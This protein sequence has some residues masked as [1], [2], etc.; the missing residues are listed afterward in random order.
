MKN[1][2][3]FTLI[4]LLV[5]V[6]IIG[7]LAVVAVPQYQIAVDKA[8]ATQI[9][10]IA[11]SIKDA[12]ERYY[13]ANGVYAADLEE[14]D[15]DVS[16][17]TQKGINV[18]YVACSPGNEAAGILLTGLG[19][20]YSKHF[21]QQCSNMSSYVGKHSCLASP[22]NTR[23]NLLCAALANQPPKAVS[24]CNDYCRYYF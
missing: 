11:K 4:E 8:K 10:T 1:K 9:V 15:I 22:S 13:L 17:L 23:G 20:R 19:V 18:F 5:V 2:Q 3:A 12:Q 7:I 14:L 16:S 24:Q 21:D 6:L